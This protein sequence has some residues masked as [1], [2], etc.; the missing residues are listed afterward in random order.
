V[1]GGACACVCVFL[2]L[3]AARSPARTGCDGACSCAHHACALPHLTPSRAPR[4]PR[5]PTHTNARRRA[6]AAASSTCLC[7]RWA[8][9]WRLWGCR[10]RL[11]RSPRWTCRQHSSPGACC[12]GC[13]R[14]HLTAHPS[15]APRARV[16]APTPLPACHANDN[17][18]HLRSG[19]AQGAEAHTVAQRTRCHV[20]VRAGCCQGARSCRPRLT[21]PLL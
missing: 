18:P 9:P 2:C 7:R 4:Q 11:C 20:C 12:V 13:A 5:A 3:A 14:V 15:T 8:P 1:S 21:W 6:A 10:G 17:P 19:T 16:R